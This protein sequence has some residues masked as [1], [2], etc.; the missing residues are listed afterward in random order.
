MNLPPIPTEYFIFASFFG[1][2]YIAYQSRL[3]GLETQRERERYLNDRLGEVTHIGDIWGVA[4]DTIRFTESSGFW[5]RKKKF[6]LGG[7]SGKSTAVIRYENSSI[8]EDLWETEGLQHFLKEYEVDVKHT[9]TADHLDPTIANFQ[10]ETADPDKVE[11]FFSTLITME[12][13]LR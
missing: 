12:K 9:G 5:Y 2:L 3:N 8:P 10:F 6:L 4:I 11:N 7:I 1:T 13:N